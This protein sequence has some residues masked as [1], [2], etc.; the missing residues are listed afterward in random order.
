MF[1][2]QLV[3][4]SRCYGL[5]SSMRLF[6]PFGN[7]TALYGSSTGSSVG[8]AKISISNQCGNPIK[9]FIFDTAESRNHLMENDFKMCF[10]VETSKIVG[11]V[12]KSAYKKNEMC[13]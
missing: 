13:R 7:K 11:K 4:K 2:C 1:R 6:R 12:S 9:P 8:R 3:C 5:L 10:L